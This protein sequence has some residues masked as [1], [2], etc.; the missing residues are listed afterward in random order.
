MLQYFARPQTLVVAGRGVLPPGAAARPGSARP[1]LPG[2]RTAM[3]RRQM[4]VIYELYVQQKGRWNLEAQFQSHERQAA[5]EEAKEL[6]RQPHI[7]GAKVARERIDD[8]TGESTESTIYNSD[9]KKP[10]A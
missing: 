4:A 1:S 5:I 10:G 7:D 3:G 6:E 2:R 9:R 8:A